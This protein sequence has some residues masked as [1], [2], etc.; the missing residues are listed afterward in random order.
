MTTIQFDI[1]AQ[2]FKVVNEGRTAFVPKVTF[3][4]KQVDYDLQDSARRAMETPGDV[5]A[6]PSSTAARG[7]KPRNAQR[8]G[9]IQ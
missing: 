6:V 3:L 7:M 1:E 2:A 8:M 9:V 5:V 4:L